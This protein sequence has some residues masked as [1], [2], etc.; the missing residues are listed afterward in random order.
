MAGTVAAAALLV[1]PQVSVGTNGN[2]PIG[3]SMESR[4]RG[5]ADVAVGDSALSQIE[6]PAALTL[7][8]RGAYRLDFTGQLL[9][10]DIHWRGPID[11]AD[12][13]INVMPHANLGLAFPVDEKLT[14]GLAFHSK[15]GLATRYHMRHLRIRWMERRVYSDMKNG[16]LVLNAAY[17]LTEKL[18]VGAGVRGEIV[19]GEMSAVIGPADVELG[20]GYAYGGGAQ[21][22]LHYKA[23][24]DLTFGLAYQSPSWFTDLEGGKA[25]MS[26]NG[27][28]RYRLGEF[29][30]DKYRL[31]QEISGGAAWDVTDWFKLIG[32]I[33]WLNY[34]N[35]AFRPGSVTTDGWVNLGLPLPAGYEDQWIFILGSEFKLDEHWTL[36]LGYN[37]GT[38]P[39]PRENLFPVTSII[40]QH[41]LTAGLRYKRDNWWVGGGYILGLPASMSGNGRSNIP[42]G[43]DYGYSKVTQIQHSIFMGFGF[44]W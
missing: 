21:L 6:N 11:S 22:G 39:L 15:S 24:D 16:A 20:R 44:S 34:S 40:T 29:R 28:R 8:P 38:N 26:L 30:V 13:E 23:R 35:D 42:L 27:R 7:S 36:G 25:E 2:E 12:S 31:P 3:V 9:M 17:E 19:T 4:S 43:I 32:E 1:H 14:W 41:H 18:S 5:G 37:Y 33:R 10:P